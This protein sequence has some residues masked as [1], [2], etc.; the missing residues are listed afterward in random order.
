MILVRDVPGGLGGAPSPAPSG[1][2]VLAWRL[3]VSRRACRTDRTRRPASRRGAAG[4]I[5]SR[6]RVSSAGVEPPERAIGFWVAAFRE[7]FEEAGIL[8]AYG[9]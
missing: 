7:A 2:S 8:L 3:R 9:A 6:R 4:S 1:E 5:V